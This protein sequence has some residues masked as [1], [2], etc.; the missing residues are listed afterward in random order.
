MALAAYTANGGVYTAYAAFCMRY[1]VY[2][3][4][5]VRFPFWGMEANIKI[6]IL[7]LASNVI[8]LFLAVWA[9]IQV[10]I[11]KLPTEHALELI[12][13]GVNVSGQ[14]EEAAEAFETAKRQILHNHRQLQG[15]HQALWRISV[16]GLSFASII[17][18][19]VAWMGW[20]SNKWL[21]SVTPQSGAP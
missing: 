6:I 13:N 3:L 2:R 16:F 15:Q 14:T 4:I 5:V 12:A 18:G 7:C 21:K 20:K 1:G 10:P 19:A 17:L 9:A 11:M 8:C